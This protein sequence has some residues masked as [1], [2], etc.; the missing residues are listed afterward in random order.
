MIYVYRRQ[1]SDSAERLREIL[2]ARRVRDIN[3]YRQRFPLRIRRGDQIICWGESLGEI[4]GVRILN[5]VPLVNKWTDAVRLTA[6][7]VP[8]I[9]VERQRPTQTAQNPAQI[10][11]E[12]LNQV[13]AD[14]ARLF[15]TANYDQII[16]MFDGYKAAVEAWKVASNRPI[17][18]LQEWLGR[19]NYHIGGNDLLRPPVRPDFYSRKEPIINEF[20]I[21]SFLGQSIRGGKKVHRENF[22][23]TPHP[24]IRSHQAGWRLSYGVPETIRQRHRDIAHN[25]I[26]ALGLDFGAVDI[27][28]RADRSLF[29]LEVNRAP[30]IEGG[31]IEK[32]AEGITRWSRG[33]EI[34][35]IGDN[36]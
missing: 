27:G 8:T 3:Y 11:R 31:T 13:H 29:V 16:A 10:E 35:Q 34:T 33:Q 7:G 25:A 24:W 12:R 6:A 17:P 32:Y 18:T 28:E 14:L 15:P 23:S 19:T 1:V 4:P 30:G 21:H 5:G 22:G 9:A 20:R 26:R 2:G 36:P